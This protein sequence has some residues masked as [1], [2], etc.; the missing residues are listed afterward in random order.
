MASNSNISWNRVF[1][2]AS[3]FGVPVISACIWLVMTITS[4]KDTVNIMSEKQ[5]R[6]EAR[7]DLMDLKLDRINSRLDT[8]ALRQKMTG[9][10][11]Q[12]IVNGQR[13]FVPVN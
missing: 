6:T 10:F 11:T 9:M 8:L 12:K 13:V 2:V 4:L 7:M 3:T 1:G 5:T